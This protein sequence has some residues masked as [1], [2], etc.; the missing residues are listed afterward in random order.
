MRDSNPYFSEVAGIVAGS[1]QTFKPL[2][3]QRAFVAYVANRTPVDRTFRLKFSTTKPPGS[4]G[5][6]TSSPSAPRATSVTS[7]SSPIRRT[8]RRCGCSPT[9]ATPPRRFASMS[10]DRRHRRRD[11]GQRAEGD[12][13][14]QSRSEQRRAD[15]GARARA[16]LRRR[17]LIQHAELHNP[18]ISSPQI[19]TFNVRAPQISS[20]QISTPQISS[21][22]ISTPQISTPQ[23][24]PQISTPQI[25]TPPVGERQRHG[26]HLYGQQ[27]RQHL[28]RLQRAVQRAE[29]R[30]APDERELPVPGDRDA[31]QPGAGVC[32]DGAGLR[33][34]GGA[35]GDGAREHSDSGSCEPQIATINNP[36]SPPRRF[37]RRRSRPSGWSPKVERRDRTR[38]ATRV[39]KT[40]TRRSFRTKSRSHCAR[41]VSRRLRRADRR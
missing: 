38:T 33:P 19:S 16:G 4:T 3:V 31:H 14:P 7:R 26:R 41:P 20:P 28:V 13:R 35:A 6:S 25:S 17:G 9:S 36:R 18:Q 40:P 23:T 29:R 1:P 30:R 5:P 15:A 22:Q 2:T 8:C 37:R 12:D 10:G 21:P 39:T 34:G 24:T 27:H 11:Q 32:A